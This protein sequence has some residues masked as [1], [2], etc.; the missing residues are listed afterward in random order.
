MCL[1]SFSE[2]RPQIYSYLG[3]RNVAECPQTDAVIVG[4]LDELKNV[5]RFRYRYERFDEPPE[6]LLKEPYLS[7]LK[8]CSGV[9]LGVMTLG[10]EVD[11]RI[12]SIGRTDML[13]SVIFDACASALLEYLS[14]GYEKEIAKEIGKSLS[15]RFC[16][17]YGGSDVSDIR[18][19]FSYLKPESIGVTLTDT[20]Y[21]LPSK[22]MAGILAIGKDTAKSC[23]G[24]V[25][26]KHCAYRKE[27]TRCYG[28]T[29]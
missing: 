24:C 14:D 28:S 11:R 12:K 5:Q 27:G 22:S 20:D 29:E 9:I 7:F 6:F 16:P 2:I 19:I 15:Y 18:G 1:P 21:M 8:G 4:C 10:T 13:K 25:L 3:F 23:G 17:G 26:L